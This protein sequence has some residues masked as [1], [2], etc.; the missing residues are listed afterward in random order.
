MGRRTRLKKKKMINGEQTTN[1]PLHKVS[2]SNQLLI[3]ALLQRRMTV[4]AK[5]EDDEENE[6][7]SEDDDDLQQFFAQLSKKNWMNLLKLMK[8]E[9]EQKEMLHKQEDILMRKIEDLEKLTKEHEKLKCSHDDLVQR[10]ENISIEQTS[11]TNDLSCA[12][13]LEKENTMLKDIIEKLNLENLALHERHDM[14]VCSHNKFMDSH[15]MLEMALEVVLT[16]LKSYQPHTCTHVEI[17]TMLPCANH[18]CSQAS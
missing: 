9:E 17:E 6:S 14:L 12:A 5:G 3:C 10:Y 8:R 7:D 1:P 18:Y 15:I 16:N 2:L 4:K 11:Y 13:Q